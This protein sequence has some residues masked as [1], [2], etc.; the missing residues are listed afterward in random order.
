MLK[1]KTASMAKI[2]SVNRYTFSANITDSKVISSGRS[3]CNMMLRKE[4][5]IFFILQ[6]YNKLAGLL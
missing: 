6:L 2:N 1:D 4:T 3:D 5:K